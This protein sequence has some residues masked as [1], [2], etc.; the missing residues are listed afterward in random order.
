M[1]AGSR[2][3]LCFLAYLK[4]PPSFL[5]QYILI[6]DRKTY[7]DYTSYYIVLFQIEY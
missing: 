6:L 7:T 5:V 3:P 2:D 4:L 1:A